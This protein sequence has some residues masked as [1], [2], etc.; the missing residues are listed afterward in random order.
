MR[1]SSLVA[2]VVAGVLALF[3]RAPAHAAP[4]AP[5]PRPVIVPWSNLTD[6]EGAE[7][8]TQHAAGLAFLSAFEFDLAVTLGLTGDEPASSVAGMVGLPLGPLVVGLGV[9]G[10]GDGGLD[11]GTTTRVDFGFALRLGDAIGLGARWEWLANT[12]SAAID[13]YAAVGVSATLRP[14]RAFS[15]ALAV[16][17]MNRPQGDVGADGVARRFEP[18]ARLGFGF[19]PGVEWATFGLEASRT[20]GADALWTLGASARLFLYRG[21]SLGAWARATLS[22]VGG[23]LPGGDSARFEA[24]LAL[25]VSQGGLGAELGADLA[26]P[27]QDSQGIRTSLLMR[28][29]ADRLPTIAPPSNQVVRLVVSGDAPERPRRGLFSGRGAAFGDVLAL[30]DRVARDPRVSGLLVQINDAPNWAQAWELRQAFERIRKLGKKVFAT[31]SVGDMRAEYLASAADEIWLHAAGGLTLTGLAI[32]QSYYLGLLEKLGVRAEFV[33]FEDYKSAP[34]SF[35]RAG[36]SAAS[37]EQTR[38][39]LGAFDAEW[40]RAVSEGRKQTPEALKTALAAGPQTMNDAR[41]QGFVDALVEAD[42]V[43]DLLRASMGRDVVLLDS[44]EPWPEVPPRWG[45]PR[46]VAIV[47]V[48]GSI[49]DGTSAG[50]LPLPIPF[51][52]GETTGDRSFIEALEGAMHDPEVAGIV[53]RVDSGGGSA[54]ASDRMYRAVLAAAKR[55]PLVV[56]FGAIAASG[57]YYLAAGAPSIL[58]T[59]IT[60]TG[61]IGIF[62][63][64]ADISGLYGLL[65]ITTHTERSTD[66]ADML[67]MHRPF[68][69]DERARAQVVLKAYYD[70]FVGVVAEG[71]KLP[72]ED[73]YKVARGRGW[74]GSAAL[75]HKLVDG[76][77]GLWDAIKA[78]RGQAG[79]D[80]NDPVVLRYV[81]TLGALSGI[82]RLVAQAFALATDSDPSAGTSLPAGGPFDGFAGLS[83]A[84]AALSAIERGAPLALLPFTLR[85]D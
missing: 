27:G 5:S 21:F 16:E 80:A 75:E 73:A 7:S 43:G 49:V 4:P 52:G 53:V 59:P 2:V 17:R 54:T 28:A 15:A 58:A 8:V 62:A 85:I 31:L 18:V 78:V 68:T 42:A 13:D 51:I 60:I 65:G 46:T 20:L 37:T 30:L 14:W 45:S 70:R 81:G 84:L 19:R 83:S 22:E 82:Q 71:R 36:P 11:T 38:A 25:G 41:A 10:I 61:S 1:L 77:G 12:R 44:Y 56:S 26:A 79:L 64:K 47:P 24:G 72:L 67:G 35:T 63:G 50:A 3:A 74:M 39:L 48:T 55:K 76:Y 32:T 40:L 69:D 6:L 57:G 66:R 23:G 34:E 33:K 9:A 29:R